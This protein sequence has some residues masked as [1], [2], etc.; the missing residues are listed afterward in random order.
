MGSQKLWLQDP[1]SKQWHSAHQG[2]FPE[3]R[4][5]WHDRST[6]WKEKKQ[7]QPLFLASGSVSMN[8]KPLR[9]VLSFEENLSEIKERLE[10]ISGFFERT[11]ALSWWLPRILVGRIA[12]GKAPSF[13]VLNHAGPLD[14]FAEVEAWMPGLC[15]RKGLRNSFI[16]NNNNNS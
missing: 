7:R 16:E 2:P 15:S 1:S 11:M 10:E 9:Y 8:Y 3:K 5:D 12:G 4:A 14:H 13:S 6:E